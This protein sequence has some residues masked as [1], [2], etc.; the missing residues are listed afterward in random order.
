MQVFQLKYFK[1]IIIN[2]YSILI[3]NGNTHYKMQLLYI[4]TCFIMKCILSNTTLDILYLIIR[5]L[6]MMV[7]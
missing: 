6:Y 5:A 3:F 1:F 2:N 4:V 7:A